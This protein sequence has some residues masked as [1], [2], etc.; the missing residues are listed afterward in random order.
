MLRRLRATFHPCE[1]RRLGATSHR[2]RRKVCPIPLQS[3]ALLPTSPGASHDNVRLAVLDADAP[4]SLRV[5][6]ALEEPGM[7]GRLRRIALWS[8]R[9][10]AAAEDL[11]TDAIV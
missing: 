1:A 9:S 7:Q 5:L 3:A 4:S 2:S 6:A 11:V 10:E 8:T